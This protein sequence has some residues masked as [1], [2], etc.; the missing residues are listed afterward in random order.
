MLF[1]LKLDGVIVI[2]GLGA[3]W[4]FKRSVKAHGADAARKAA[5]LVALLV[6]SI[7]AGLFIGEAAVR[8]AT[9]NITTTGDGKSWYARRH[10]RNHPTDL[11]AWGFREREIGL[12]PPGTY[13]IVVIGDSFTYGQGLPEQ[14]RL[15][16]IL[17]VRLNSSG[18]G[19]EVLNFGRSGAETVDELA[20]LEK[21]L[22]IAPDYV[23]LQWYRNDVEGHDKSGRPKGW[24]LLP[25]SLLTSFL[26]RHSA[27]F[28][29]LN[30][31]WNELQT[32]L[33]V[34]ERAMKST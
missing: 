2:L 24:R 4:S 28:F 5:L 29:I 3:T 12:K 6:I 10:A 20:L 11:N 19:F 33:G 15:T 7:L 23:Q 22:E 31:Q 21:V 32:L 26:H 27:L 13:R 25:S 1:L 17:E 8:I 30:S 16:E 34:R 9:R 18:G 14:D